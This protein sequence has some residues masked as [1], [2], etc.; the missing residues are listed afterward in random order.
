MTSSRASSTIVAC[1]Q[2]FR[3]EL[4]YLPLSIDSP[5]YTK[6]AEKLEFAGLFVEPKKMWKDLSWVQLH[7]PSLQGELN[8]SLAV[9][10]KGK[11]LEQHKPL[12]LLIESYNLPMI[13]L[14]EMLN[15]S[16]TDYVNTKYCCDLRSTARDDYQIPEGVKVRNFQLGQD[17]SLYVKLYNEA[18]GHLGSTI[19]S[20][21][22][23]KEIIDRETFDPA[24]Y[25]IAELD[26]RPVG[27]FSIE[28]LTAEI[29]Y[30]YQTGL[31]KDAIGKGIGAAMYS[32]ARKFAVSRGV[33]RIWVSANSENSAAKKFFRKMSFKE[34]FQITGYLMQ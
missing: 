13:A 29:A 15:L 22:L 32:Q 1:H 14:Q 10:L 19:D 8:S 26:Q 9:S 27:L 20:G 4:G 31:V 17:D 25:F 18:L 3:D 34:V 5:F 7:V 28:L 23:K 2:K 12:V 21:F 30:I 6:V 33:S 24:G 11:L 16:K